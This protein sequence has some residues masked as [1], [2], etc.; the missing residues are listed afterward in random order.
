MDEPDLDPRRHRHALRGLERINLWSGTSRSFWLALRS[1]VQQTPAR[2]L[3][4]LDVATGAGDVPIRLWQ[5]GRRAGLRLDIQGCD[6]SPQA[7]AH[8]R[9]RAEEAGAEVPFFT[10]DVLHDPLPNGFD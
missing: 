6:R 3:R 2:P 7:L 1:L 10:C 5:R 4:L 9:Q 8:A